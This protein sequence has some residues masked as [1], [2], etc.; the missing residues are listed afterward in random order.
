MLA[1]LLFPYDDD[2]P[3]L[4]DEWLAELEH[5]GC[6]VR[7]QADGQSY[8]QICN[9]L[10][11]QKIDKPT[12]SKIPE[13]DESSRILASNSRDV[14]GGSKEGIKGRDQRK[15]SKETSPV[16]TSAPKIPDCP[17][18]EIL[19]LFAENLPMLTQPRI[20]DGARAEL[21]KTRWRYLSKPNGATKGYETEADGLAFFARFFAYVAKSK[22]LTEGIP[23]KPGDGDGV[24]QPDLP[25]LL[26]A[27]NFAKV[28][29]GK[30]HGDIDA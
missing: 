7:Y 4:I 19:A 8:M 20:W 16:G 14:V 10:I 5:E 9:W 18:K 23:R 12:K 3:N 2:A 28:I 29:E 27:A 1:S 22:T 26:K 15:G 6:L 13:F 11:H 30:Y 17:Q 21:L 24:W 25:W